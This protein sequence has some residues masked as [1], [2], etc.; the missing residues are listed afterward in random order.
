M[1]KTYR[2]P[3][4]FRRGSIF[5][6]VATAIIYIV[7][8]IAGIG[9]ET[10][11]DLGGAVLFVVLSSPLL[12][13]MPL[14]LLWQN[15]GEV[16]L[17]DD[18]VIWRHWGREKRLAYRDVVEVKRHDF[19]LPPNLVLRGHETTVRI[20]LQIEGYSEIY[21]ILS[22]KVPVLRLEIEAGFP[23][24]LKISPRKWAFSI[25]GTLILLAFYL[26]FGL[27]PIWSELSKESPDFSHV[28]LRNTIIFLGMLGFVFIP[29]IYFFIVLSIAGSM[30]LSQPIAFE[31]A[32]REI[33]YRRPFERWKGQSVDDLKAIVLQSI[34]TNVRALGAEGALAR[35]TVTTYQLALTFADGNRVEIGPD[36]LR[37]FGTSPQALFTRLQ[38]LYP[39]ASSK[40]APRTALPVGAAGN[41]PY[42]LQMTPM[43]RWN[44][45]MAT[46]FFAACTLGSAGVILWL[47]LSNDPGASDK[48]TILFSGAIGTAF[49]LGM[50]V[51]T[52]SS[53][54]HPR[55]PHRLILT[56][57]AVRFR[58]PLSGWQKWPADEIVEVEL[59]PVQRK[60]YRPSGGSYQQVTVTQHEVEIHFTGGRNLIINQDRA[61]QFDLSPQQVYRIFQRR[62]TDTL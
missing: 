5:V 28:L 39:Q 30:T 17:T 29:G 12:V 48:G 54:F 55:Q 15:S 41:T 19:H 60:M 58:Y 56:D 13:G 4:L 34:R 35:E 26:G 32:E 62:Y 7:F 59:K 42:I 9:K 2:V 52:F 40:E 10:G 45:T 49:L 27:L 38:R 18:E 53:A 20:H 36:R 31:F 33:R 61:K 37:Q 44:A 57:D 14:Y 25:M 46:A 21:Q 3:H 11:V 51:L 8:L 6:L 43:R 50:T 23:Y 22:R 1:K 24:E 47:L 16:T